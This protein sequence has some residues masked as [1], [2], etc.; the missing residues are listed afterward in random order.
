MIE[1]E[2]VPFDN[3]EEPV[4]LIAYQQSTDER[5]QHT[6]NYFFLVNDCSITIS[7]ISDY[8]E[9]ES[10]FQ[11]ALLNCSVVVEKHYQS[12]DSLFQS[13]KRCSSKYVPIINS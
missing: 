12:F 7:A 4:S 2:S 11:N 13:I 5:M 9:M 1:I 3:N 8:H 6:N 10:A